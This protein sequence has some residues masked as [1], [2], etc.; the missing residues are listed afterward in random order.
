MS[1]L[2]IMSVI[3]L[4]LA[5]QYIWPRIRL[6]DPMRLDDSWGEGLPLGRGSNREGI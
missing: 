1:E 3:V 4:A 6:E 2:I 5:G